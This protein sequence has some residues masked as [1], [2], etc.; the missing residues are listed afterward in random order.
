MK[1]TEARGGRT[2]NG[3]SEERRMSDKRSQWLT[4]KVRDDEQARESLQ[5]WFATVLPDERV[6][7]AAI[8]RP[9]TGGSSETL[10][11]DVTR[12]TGHA[13]LTER[14]VVKVE[15]L[16][17][18]LNYSRSLPDEYRLLETLSARGLPVP[19]PRWF[20]TDPAIL[21]ASFF[22]M[23]FVTGR[24]PPHRP[25]YNA[26]GWLH[27][28]PVSDR[29]H[30]WDSAMQGLC[31]L[32]AVPAADVAFLSR[33][34]LGGSGIEQQLG[35]WGAALGWSTD[36]AAP[37][38]L[39]RALG[40]LEDRMP[41]QPDRLSWGDA[42]IGNMLFAGF[43][44]RAIVDW[45]LASLAGPLADL[46]WWLFFD[47][48]HSSDQNLPRLDGLGDRKAT[49][50]RFEELTDHSSEH[51]PWFMVFTALRLSTL[52]IRR[53]QMVPIDGQSATNNYAY[54]YLEQLMDSVPAQY[55]QETRAC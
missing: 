27:D 19:A 35:Y 49:I 47:D 48:I 53:L 6:R 15:P 7:V 11:V 16:D 54:R 23:D 14:F 21:G 22:V 25:S 2:E 39:R 46:S 37:A 45:E 4:P 18:Q 1:A 29:R 33:P 43:D 32:A 3:E 52:F 44:C 10:F 24:T 5:G 34:A 38:M 28:A 42:R 36:G 50:A 26:E 17:F 9:A 8:S 20:E 13:A 31:G 51:L 12:D 40:W 55:S 41:A 30:L